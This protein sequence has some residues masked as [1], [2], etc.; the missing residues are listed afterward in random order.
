M[1]EFD[2]DTYQQKSRNSRDLSYEPGKNA[3]KYESSRPGFQKKS[4]SESSKAAS[5]WVEAAMDAPRKMPKLDK[6]K[7][8]NQSGKNKFSGN[9]GKPGRRNRKWNRRRK[10]SLWQRILRFFGLAPKKNRKFDGNRGSKNQ[11]QQ[12][13]NK[14]SGNR[15][16]EGS[17]PQGGD[18]QRD[19]QRNRSG[20]DEPRGEGRKRRRS[21]SRSNQNRRQNQGAEASA[22]QDAGSKSDTQTP[23]A[24][25]QQGER[26]ERRERRQDR[27]G[28]RPEGRERRPR[29]RDRERGPRQERE[30]RK[31]QQSTPGGKVE[32]IAAPKTDTSSLSLGAVDMGGGSSS[33]E[34]KSQTFAAPRGKRNRRATARPQNTGGG[35]EFVP[36]PIDL[37]SKSEKPADNSEN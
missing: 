35:N 7:S 19:N 21:R 15:R 37:P 22:S 8:G 18:R 6:K 14:R 13:Q 34:N 10:P 23:N 2:E 1:P 20:E 36:H 11:G 29:E 4:Q 17:K 5:L 16:P 12:R 33:E 31:P 30:E 26:G 3:D 24:E 27:G 32:S 9:K 25:K 28:R